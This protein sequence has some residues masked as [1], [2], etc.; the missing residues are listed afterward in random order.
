MI[1]EYAAKYPDIVVP[2]LREKNIG[3][4]AN[5]VGLLK[6]AKGRYIAGCE[7]DDFWTDNKKLELQF[8]FLERRKDHIACSHDIEI[9]N[10][11]GTSA[12]K[13]KINW[14][15][16]NRHY[17]LK[18][19]KGIMLPGHPVALVFRNIFK[20]QEDPNRLLDFHTSIA[21]R[22]LAVML[23]V[24]GKIY[25]ADRKMAAY[26]LHSSN[27]TNMTNSIYNNL[28]S[29]LIDYE[30]NEKIEEYIYTKLHKRISFAGFRWKLFI[31]LGIKTILRFNVNTFKIY[32]K[33]FKMHIKWLLNK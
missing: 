20:T 14:I 23:A 31:K 32:R 9:V 24:R 3:A 4:V 8:R 15:S 1:L 26:R 18:D 2:V 13:Q 22:T 25:R 33:L 6:M 27:K 7:G 17:R 12:D 19:Y 29:Y 28:R 21:D 16:P 30:L 10:E 11:D 5:L